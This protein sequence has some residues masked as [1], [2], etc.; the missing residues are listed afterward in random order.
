PNGG[1][2]VVFRAFL[3]VGLVCGFSLHSPATAWAKPK[4]ATF[5]KMIE[6]SA[7][8]VVATFLGELPDKQ[9]HTI[10]VQV[11]EVLKGNL[12]PGKHHL[13]FQD[14]PHFGAKG[15]EFVAFLDN[16]RVWRFM[17]SPMKG[18]TK[19]DQ[20]VLQLT[21]FYDFNAYWVTP[22]LVTLDLLKTYLKA[23][24]LVY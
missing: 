21:G 1:V 24:S 7:T 18:H 23:G 20:G 5:E 8:I 4:H 9:K 13:V 6:D 11:T 16:E 14:M 22:G 2:P 15:E 19:V 10:Q 17:A 3:V 12:K